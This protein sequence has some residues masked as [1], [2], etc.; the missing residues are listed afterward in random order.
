MQFLRGQ[1]GEFPNG[2]FECEFVFFADVLALGPLVI[3][4]TLCAVNRSLVQVVQELEQLQRLGV[5][6]GSES[7]KSCQLAVNETSA[8]ASLAILE[9]LRDREEEDWTPYGPKTG[10]A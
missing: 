1:R 6:H 2:V 4:E 7:L 10:S 9:V 8:W 3:Y 5:F